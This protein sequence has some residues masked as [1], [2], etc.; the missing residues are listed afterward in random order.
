MISSFLASMIL[1]SNDAAEES[2]LYSLGWQPAGLR[3]FD[4][5]YRTLQHG[6]LQSDAMQ[7]TTIDTL[8]GAGM[9]S[10]RASAVEFWG[11]KLWAT[12]SGWG[13]ASGL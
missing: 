1:T 12:V 4:A 9:W 3:G 6:T 2:I 5:Q 8:I 10:Y 11:S 13:S 7:R